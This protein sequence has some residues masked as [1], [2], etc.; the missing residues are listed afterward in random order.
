MI[1][2]T[3]SGQDLTVIGLGLE[4]E[5]VRRL[6]AGEPIRVRLADLG[7]TGASGAIQVI[8]FS[9]SSREALVEAMRPFIGPETVILDTLG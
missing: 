1:K 2:F 4:P 5:N 9:G 8:I 3:A 7:F 6:Q